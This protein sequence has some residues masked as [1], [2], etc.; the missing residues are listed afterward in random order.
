MPSL[1]TLQ[2]LPVGLKRCAYTAVVVQVLV[3]DLED[4][5]SFHTKN[6]GDVIFRR[7]RSED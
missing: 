4:R 1:P 3:E 5:V 6:F 7:E 2:P